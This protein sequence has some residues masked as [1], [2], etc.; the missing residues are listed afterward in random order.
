VVLCNALTLKRDGKT[1]S[2]HRGARRTRGEPGDPHAHLCR[3]TT[4]PRAQS[5]IETVLFH[6]LVD[7]EWRL[8]SDKPG[9]R[10]S[11]STSA[12]TGQR[13]AAFYAFVKDK[14]MSAQRGERCARRR[15]ADPDGTLRNSS[16][17]LANWIWNPSGLRF[18]RPR[19]NSFPDS[20]LEGANPM[21][22]IDHLAVN[23]IRILVR[24]GRAKGELRPPRHADGR[25]PHGLRA[26]GQ[27]R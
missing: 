24:R 14:V 17:T 9:G 20:I 2:S 6:T 5:A 21:S 13:L 15:E 22:K 1:I 19:R 25:G 11:T 3:R 12:A 4:G 23:A 26:V 16:R 10:A 27:S 18:P 8:A 7:P